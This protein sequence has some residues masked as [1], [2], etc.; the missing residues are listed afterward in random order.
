[1]ARK[2]ET[3]NVDQEKKI[4]RV[5][6]TL[7]ERFDRSNT[8]MFVPY[9]R[10]DELIVFRKALS[11][12]PDSDSVVELQLREQ[13]NRK[14]RRSKDEVSIGRFKGSGKHNEE[15]DDV[16][17]GESSTSSLDDIA[18]AEHFS[19]NKKRRRG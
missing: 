5:E 3:L 16:G 2:E 17:D 19:R 14:L 13:S 4:N 18:V 10:H 7:P 1:M 15:N 6:W 11:F 9:I 12:A 8:S